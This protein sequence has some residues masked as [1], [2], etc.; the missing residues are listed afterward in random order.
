MDQ[1]GGMESDWE[2]M[3]CTLKVQKKA[4]KSMLK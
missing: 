2:Y 1:S 4:I 3:D